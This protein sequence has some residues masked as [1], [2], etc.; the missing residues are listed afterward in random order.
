MRFGLYVILRAICV[1]RYAVTLSIDPRSQICLTLSIF[2]T[3]AKKLTC[4][5]YSIYCT[6]T[7]RTG[8]RYYIHTGTTGTYSYA[9]TST[10]R[11]HSTLYYYTLL[12]LVHQY[13]CGSNL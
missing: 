9:R 3:L 11:V 2:E 4:L 7:I 6:R 10:V 8:T 1:D 5:T 13:K 12:V